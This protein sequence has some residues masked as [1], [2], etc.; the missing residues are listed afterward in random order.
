M[1]VAKEK[2]MRGTDGRVFLRA[3]NRNLASDKH[4]ILL[5]I[6]PGPF[7]CG[8]PVCPVAAWYGNFPLSLDQYG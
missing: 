2:V 3:Q 8:I 7:C 5:L 6:F 4:N 1:D